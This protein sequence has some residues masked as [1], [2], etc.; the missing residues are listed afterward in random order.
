MS[1]QEIQCGSI[2]RLPI[3][4]VADRAARALLQFTNPRAVCIDP[5]GRVSIEYPK[6]AAEYDLIGVYA[7]EKGLLELSRLLIEDLTF[8]AKAR[9]FRKDR[10]RK[11]EDDYGLAA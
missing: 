8:E 2:V 1:N 5:V 4:E 9:G 7:P 10:R 11:V 3:S 6:H